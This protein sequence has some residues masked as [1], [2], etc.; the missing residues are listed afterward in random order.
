[1]QVGRIVVNFEAV[2]LLC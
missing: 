2:L 1:M